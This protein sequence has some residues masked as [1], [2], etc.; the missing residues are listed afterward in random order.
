MERAVLGV[1]HLGADVA[2]QR[3]ADATL[4]HDRTEKG[5]GHSDQGLACTLLNG[6]A[7]ASAHAQVQVHKSVV[8]RATCGLA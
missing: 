8:T 7:A 5:L 6:L 2:P 1:K 4:R 3:D